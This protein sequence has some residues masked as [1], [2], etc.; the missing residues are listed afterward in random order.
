MGLV[1]PLPPFPVPLG[2]EGLFSCIPTNAIASR[3]IRRAFV[4]W[5]G[6]GNHQPWVP[7]RHSGTPS[8]PHHL[9]QTF[10]PHGGGRHWVVTE[11]T[12]FSV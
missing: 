7:A 9:C 12:C 3:R 8:L 5:D 6:G 2:E 1:V 10:H 11:E 4:P